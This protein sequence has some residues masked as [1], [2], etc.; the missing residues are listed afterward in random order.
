MYLAEGEGLE[1]PERAPEKNATAEVVKTRLD[2]LSGLSNLDFDYE[3][4]RAGFSGRPS[5]RDLVAFTFQPQNIVANPDVLFFKADTY[6]HREK[7]RTVFPYV[8][9]ALSAEGVAAQHELR[10]IRRRREQKEREL[11]A[12]REVSERWMAELRAS[13]LKARELGLLGDEVPRAATQE[14]LLELLGKVVRRDAV[15]EVEEKG[16]EGTV[17]ELLELEGEERVVDGELVSLRRRLAEMA[18]LRESTARYGGALVVQRERLGIARWVK[19]LGDERHE[20]PMCG[21]EMEKGAGVVQELVGSLERVEEDV[22]RSGSIAAAFDRE[23]LRVKRDIA[24]G[25]EKLG[26]IAV[27]KRE[28][29]MRRGDVEEA[30]YRESEIERFRGRI[31]KTLEI[32]EAV[33]QGEALGSDIEELR[34]REDELRGVILRENVEARKARA[35]EKVAT[36]ASRLLPGLDAERPDEPIELSIDDL[37]VRIKGADRTDYLWE[38]GSGANWLAYHV[39]VSLALQQFF[40]GTRA[41]PVPSFLVYDQPSQVYFPRKLAGAGTLESGGE[42]PVLADEDVE[43][44][45]RVF[46]TM[47]AAVRGSEARFQALVLDHAGRDVW[48]EVD[49]VHLVEEWRGGAKLVP[50]E[51]LR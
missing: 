7:L 45:R 36:L 4:S 17:A 10:W 6:E 1:V 24:I 49:G 30:R 44:V 18:R 20:C 42:E 51:W 39:A 8:L 40:L 37:T 12:L 3:G 21:S 31:E 28:I 41:N 19:A 25:V 14:V 23:M 32:Y 38:I 5:V 33:E 11:R 47:S 16:I 48:G 9:G 22:K 46:I 34:S 29:G 26:A 43:A 50:A 35:L 15:P 13:V 27:R 2:E